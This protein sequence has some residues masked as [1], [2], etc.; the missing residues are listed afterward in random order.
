MT[1]RITDGTGGILFGNANQNILISR[2]N[3]GS[4]ITNAKQ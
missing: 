4:R 3:G 2:P 1:T